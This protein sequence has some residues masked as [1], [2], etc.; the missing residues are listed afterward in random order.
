MIWEVVSRAEGRN[1]NRL[2]KKCSR[3]VV[4]I[5]MDSPSSSVALGL[6]NAN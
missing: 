3:K 1:M 2:R 6:I 4:L 5:V